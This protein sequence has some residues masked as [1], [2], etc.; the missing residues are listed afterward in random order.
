MHILIVDDEAL[1]RSRLRTLIGDCEHGPHCVQEAV[2][3]QQALQLL[4]AAQPTPVQVLLLDIHMPGQNG[5]QLAQALAQLPQPPAIVFVT[6][7]ANHA[8]DAFELDAADYLT[9]PVRLQ[10]LQQALQKAERSL[11]ARSTVDNGPALLIQERGATLRLPLSEVRYLKAEQKYITVRTVQRN[12]ILDGALADLETR[13][14][15]QLL[16]VHR[17]ALVLRAALRG[18]EKY[19]DP[20][21]GEGWG[22]RLQGVPE[23]LPISRRQLAVVRAE[24]KEI[25]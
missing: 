9:K 18:L 6:A 21:E 14:S 3:A 2:D 1:A 12:Y 16:R 10:R 7:H 20:D 23:L 25:D 11:N 13:H 22:L 15:E 5:L 4:Q 19:D 8:L 24:L 17:N